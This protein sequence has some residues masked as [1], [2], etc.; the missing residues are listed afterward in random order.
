MVPTG[1]DTK[2]FQVILRPD[3]LSSYHVTADEVVRALRATNENTSAGF[4]LEGGQ[5]LLIHGVGRV[6]TPAD[7]GETVVAMRGTEPVLV[8]QLGEVRVGPALK[9]G[10][11]SHDG[12]PAVILGIQKQPGANTLELTK[13]LDAEL[14][15]IQKTLPE[16]M[17]I[18]R[19][20]FRQSDFI[21]VSIRNV[22]APCATSPNRGRASLRSWQR[23]A[24]APTRATKPSCSAGSARHSAA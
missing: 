20:I 6:R 24:A 23:P 15:A 8:R 17:E 19:H 10:E 4:Y 13:R 22:S 5:Q 11:G 21:E 16:G 18:D 2:Q 9:L 12:R 1:G 7:L 3:R 14:D